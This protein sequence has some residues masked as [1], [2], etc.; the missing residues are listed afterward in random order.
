MKTPSS[1]RDAGWYGVAAL[2]SGVCVFGLLGLNRL[3]GFYYVVLHTRLSQAVDWNVKFLNVTSLVLSAL[4]VLAVIPTIVFA[5]IGRKRLTP[6]S[7]AHD[8]INLKVGL[9]LGIV[10]SS[11][12]VV[13]ILIFLAISVFGGMTR[14]KGWKTRNF[15]D[16]VGIEYRE[17][18]L[19]GAANLG[20]VLMISPG[21]GWVVGSDGQMLQYSGDKWRAVKG[22]P[23][24]V[25]IQSI[26]AVDENDVWFAGIEG[27]I[28]RNSPE[29]QF[30]ILHYDGKKI[31]KVGSWAVDKNVATIAMAGKNDGWAACSSGLLLHYD[32]SKWDPAP[33]IGEEWMKYLVFENANKGWGLGGDLYAYTD[34]EWTPQGLELFG[35]YNKVLPMNDGSVLLGAHIG[36]SVTRGGETQQLS[37]VARVKNGSM[38]QVGGFE[39]KYISGMARGP[40]GLAI[41]VGC[42]GGEPGSAEDMPFDKPGKIMLYRDGQ[43]VGQDIDF[44]FDKDP[45]GVS[46]DSADHGWIS[47]GEGTMI[48][49]RLLIAE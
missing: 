10:Y 37:S 45:R 6:A 3:L 21:N 20:Q 33:G 17:V 36:M 7:K 14:T 2:V 46:F 44:P 4:A 23:R 5:I 9:I 31:T 48:E 28:A 40:D 19:A 49:F 35:N 38:Q 41:L 22:A 43:K 26:S 30:W 18:Q 47:S 15:T 25:D 39:I 11:F 27:E 29:L 34:S 8:R 32:G 1:K 24:D 12:V 16:T 13:M 42:E